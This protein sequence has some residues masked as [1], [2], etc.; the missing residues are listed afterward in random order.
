MAVCVF[1]ESTCQCVFISVCVC[2]C[3]L[4]SPFVVLPLGGC[5]AGMSDE[6]DDISVLKQ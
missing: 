3:G 1:V 6:S 5:D 4:I 2:V